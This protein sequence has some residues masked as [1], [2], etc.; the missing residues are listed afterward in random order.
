MYYGRAIDNTILPVLNV[1]SASQAAPTENTNDKIIMLL[2]YL[3]TYPNA[4][5]RYTMS[6]MMLHID[7]DAVFLVAPKAL[8]RVAGFY[9]CGDSYTKKH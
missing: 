8:S 7:S 1:I 4:K 9:Y 2:D 6:D 5:I 3:C